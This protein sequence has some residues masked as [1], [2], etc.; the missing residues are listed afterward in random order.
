MGQKGAARQKG[1]KYSFQSKVQFFRACE[2]IERFDPR[3][4]WCVS[5][6]LPK[7]TFLRPI[8]SG[9]LNPPFKKRKQTGQS[10]REQ[11]IRFWNWPHLDDKAKQLC[12]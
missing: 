11:A 7:R 8:L 2:N 6:G 12:I 1:A 10:F 4:S 3:P 9:K 5:T